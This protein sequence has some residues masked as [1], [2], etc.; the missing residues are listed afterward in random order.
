MSIWKSVLAVARFWDQSPKEQ[1]TQPVFPTEIEAAFI[2]QCDLQHT[3]VLM[4]Y[5]EECHWM[6]IK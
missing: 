6:D 2:N 4:Y 1:S 3:T 5:T